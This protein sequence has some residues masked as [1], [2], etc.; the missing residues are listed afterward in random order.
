MTFADF[1][2]QAGF[3][4]WIGMLALAA[5]I[6]NAAGNGIANWRW[7]G[8]ITRTKHIYTGTKPEEKDS[9]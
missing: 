4:Q 1:L 7:S 6:C 5:I 3:W 9:K 8:D 2:Y